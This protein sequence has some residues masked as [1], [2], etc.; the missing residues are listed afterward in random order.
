MVLAF[1][2]TCMCALGVQNVNFLPQYKLM[3]VSATLKM[4]Q[5]G[6]MMLMTTSRLAPGIC[7]CQFTI[8]EF[9]EK[10]IFNDDHQDATA[11]H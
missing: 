2:A 8:H 9:K 6:P 4:L 10:G 5:L 11:R 1:Q 3:M 7:G